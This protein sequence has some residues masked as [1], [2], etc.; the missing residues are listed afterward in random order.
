MQETQVLSFLL[1]VQI[2]VILKN[3]DK[4]QI[5]RE[6]LHLLDNFLKMPIFNSQKLA[7]H[8]HGVEF[9]QK[10]IGDI[11]NTLAALYDF[12]QRHVKM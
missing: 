2:N 7:L 8:Q 12:L 6:Y 1:L 11:R 5:K 9:R 4:V 10:F 3:F